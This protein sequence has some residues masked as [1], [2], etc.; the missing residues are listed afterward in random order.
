MTL[1]EALRRADEAAAL[2]HAWGDVDVQMLSLSLR[3]LALVS[4]GRV[5]EGMGMLDEAGAV[6]LAG[7]V[8]DV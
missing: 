4:M 3:G 2:A 5:A 6:T 7:E 1:A 8:E